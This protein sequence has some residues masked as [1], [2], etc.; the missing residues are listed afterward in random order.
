MGSM[1]V[2]VP[3]RS[4]GRRWYGVVSIWGAGA[5]HVQMSA[6]VSGVDGLNFGVILW[7]SISAV[8]LRFSRLHVV[9][10]KLKINKNKHKIGTTQSPGVLWGSACLDEAVWWYKIDWHVKAAWPCGANCAVCM[11]LRRA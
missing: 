4:D 11:Y 1:H 5:V 8:S 9:M 6:L 10:K 2:L 3:G 7:K